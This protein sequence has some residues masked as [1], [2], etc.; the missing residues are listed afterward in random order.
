MVSKTMFLEANS[1]R[2]RVWE[3][4]RGPF[5]RLRAGSSTSRNESLRES[6]RCAQDDK[7]G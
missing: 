5:G 4:N 7:L 6:F 2:L 1:L 3:V